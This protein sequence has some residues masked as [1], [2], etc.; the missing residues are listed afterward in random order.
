MFWGGVYDLVHRYSNRGQ[1]KV[2]LEDTMPGYVIDNLTFC[3]D[4]MTS[5]GVALANMTCPSS[6]QTANCLSTALYVFWKSASINFA[7]SVTGEIFVMLNASGN[8]IYRNNSYFREYEV[9]NLTK[10][11]VTKAT[12]YIVSESS[13]SKG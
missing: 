4:K 11:K 1:S 8:P 9:P 12:V 2:T 3:G 7:K 13:L 10:G 5:D 6:N